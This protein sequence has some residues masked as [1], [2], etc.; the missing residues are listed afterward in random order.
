MKRSRRIV[1]VGGMAGGASAA[2]KARR[3]EESTDVANLRGGFLQAKLFHD[4]F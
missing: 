3:I 4:S 1:I 2:A